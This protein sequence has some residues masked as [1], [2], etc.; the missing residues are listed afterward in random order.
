MSVVFCIFLTAC[1]NDTSTGVIDGTDDPTS[2]IVAEKGEIVMYEQIT[3]EEAKKIMDSED[4]YIILDVREKAE[5]DEKHIPGAVLIPHTEIEN[6]AEK[7]IP[8][9]DTQILVYC[10][11]GRRSKLASE[12]LVKLGY[13]NVKEFGGIIEWQYEVEK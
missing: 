13:T 3:Q 10:R 7:I 1:G 12:N 11:F 9:K 2:I 8:D 6:K 4:G 5:Y